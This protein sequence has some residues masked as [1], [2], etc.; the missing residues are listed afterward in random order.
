LL[1][2]H[3]GLLL[4]LE[5][6]LK[7][8]VLVLVLVLVLLLAHGSLLL[9]LAHGSLLLLLELHH[10]LLH[11]ELL[12]VLR[13]IHHLVRIKPSLTNSNGRVGHHSSMTRVACRCLVPMLLQCQCN[14]GRLVDRPP[15][16]E[17]GSKRARI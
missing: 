9:L 17:G 2:L 4:K 13:D 16:R 1:L 5:L 11:L 15:T 12:H 8:L 3:Q 10:I 7:L 14:L 6:V